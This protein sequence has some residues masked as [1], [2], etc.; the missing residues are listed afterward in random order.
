MHSCINENNIK[1]IAMYMKNKK[2]V[3]FLSQINTS[4]E[5]VN[6]CSQIYT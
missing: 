5:T 6:A 3:E 1:Y 2:E 4:V